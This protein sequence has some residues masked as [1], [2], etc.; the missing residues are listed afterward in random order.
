MMKS[1]FPLWFN[2][3]ARP[4]PLGTVAILAFGWTVCWAVLLRQVESLR[5]RVARMEARVVVME[6]R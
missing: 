4:V 5:E 6:D 1:D 3:M 2:V